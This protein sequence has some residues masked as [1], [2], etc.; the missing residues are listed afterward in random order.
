MAPVI[1]SRE[2]LL[3]EGLVIA[4]RS[5]LRAITVRGVAARARVNL[6]SFVYHFGSREAFV[7]ELLERWYAPL[8]AEMQIAVD[9]ERPPLER[10]REMLLQFVDWV[11][12]NSGFIAH[13]VMDAASGE[14]AARKFVASLEQRHPALLLQAIGAAQAAGALRREN[15]LHVL[16]F[17]MSTLAFP[18]VLFHGVGVG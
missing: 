11:R 4:R 12:A 15:P 3:K 10:L 14:A 16:L 13:I 18:A 5:G 1:A 9:M 2:R 17:L 8:V 6:G 7:A